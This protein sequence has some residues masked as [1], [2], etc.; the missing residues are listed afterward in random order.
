[1]EATAKR[2][3]KADQ[4]KN[5]KGMNKFDELAKGLAKS[6]TRRAA[7]KK[8]GGPRRDGAGLLRAAQ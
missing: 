7:L 6:V 2:A 8:F 3:T 4:D 1:L 5:R